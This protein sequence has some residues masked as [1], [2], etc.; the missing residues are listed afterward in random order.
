MPDNI[1]K[2]IVPLGGAAILLAA[3]VYAF[4]PRPVP[5]DIS[6]AS[7]GPMIVTIDEE[8]ETRVKE[9]Y[10]VSALLPGRVLRFNGNAGDAVIAG[11][12][13]V[14]V[15][16]PSDPAFLDVRTR[17]EMEAQVRAAEAARSETVA[18]L[19]RLKAVHDYATAEYERALPLAQ[20]GTISQ[21]QLDRALMEV[22]TQAAAV[23]TAE[24]HL[25]VHEFELERARAALLNPGEPGGANMDSCCFTVK[26]PVDGRILRILQE[27]ESVVEAGTPLLEIGD[28]TEL[29]IVTDL[30][31][32]DAVTTSVGDE[33]LVEDWGGNSVLSGVVKRVEPFGFTKVSTLG[34]EEQRVNV[35]IDLTDPPESWQRLGHGY[36]VDV[37][38]IIWRADSVLRV[39]L[40]A[41]FRQG[42]DWAVFAVVDG[43]AETRRIEVDHINDRY[44]QVVGGLAEGDQI[45]EHPSDRISDGVR[46]SARNNS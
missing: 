19:E 2:K 6:A 46:V 34:I 1:R 11:E 16:R 17:S 42:E 14:A 15:I 30:L 44:A 26:S 4:W 12:T 25:T 18:E 33:V 21:S 27:S 24:A 40:S 45:I 22:R 32:K 9:A 7:V 36:R 38:I 31:S 35:I 28:P 10:L 23:Q 39:P 20:S 3:L 43:Y 41:L 13:P 29:E 8:G 5:V 37:R